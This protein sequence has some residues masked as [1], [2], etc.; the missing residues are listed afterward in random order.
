MKFANSVHRVTWLKY[1]FTLLLCF[2]V[3]PS[4]SHAFFGGKIEEFSADQVMIS[5]DGKVESTSKLYVTKDAYRMDGLPMGGPGEV[6]P[7]LTA[8]GFNKLN[9]QYIYNHDKKLFFETQLD[10]E[11]MMAKLKSYQDVDSEKILGKEKVSGYKCVKKEVITTT[12]IMG[13]KNRSKEILWQSKRFE[14][15]LRIQM[16]D[17]QIMEFRNFD[18]GKPA[19]KLFKQPAGYQK[20]ANI[21]AVMGMDFGSM[22]AE[23][24][25]SRDEKRQASP[26]QNLEDIN[27]E[28]MMSGLQQAMGENADPEQ[29][30]QLQQ[31]M[32][33]AMSGIKQTS[34]AKGAA[35]ELWQIIPQ[36]TGDKIGNEMKSPSSYSVTM[37][38]NDS[39]KQVFNF[40][41]QKLKTQ[42]WR[43]GGMFVQ[44]ERGHFSMTKGQQKLMI[45]WTDNPGMRGNY[46]T[47]Y[48]LRLSDPNI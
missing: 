9:K 18:E 20:V 42:G 24:R 28:E 22:V 21:M 35:T 27:V 4:L 23:R 46:K 39:L 17:G 45:T 25:A 32:A 43:D 44:D 5:P 40:Y 1:F 26:P 30:S 33:Q 16:E 29:M 48:N 19:K 12:T 34:T 13:I 2:T 36:R 47:F 38:S 7:N 15:P 8:M 3:L 37:G 14:F 6:T 31:I 11:D 10:E 41:Q